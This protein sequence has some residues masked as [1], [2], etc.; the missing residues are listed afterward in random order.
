MFGPEQDSLLIRALDFDAVGFDVRIIFESVVND[1]PI[2]GA[3]RLQFDDIAPAA[4]FFGGL[5]GFFDESFPGLRAVAADVHHDFRCGLIVLKK[6]SIQKVLQIAEGLS[7]TA[8][9]PAGVVRLHVQHQ[10]IFELMLVDGGLE[11][12]GFEQ[13]LQRLFRLSWHKVSVISHLFFF[14]G[15]AAGALAVPVSSFVRV[16]LVCAMVSKFCTVQ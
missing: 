6:Q 1:A 4:D 7:L 13:V 5:F 16:S 9:K 14:G 3:E 2:E 11:A 12:K 10:S 15:P 8:N